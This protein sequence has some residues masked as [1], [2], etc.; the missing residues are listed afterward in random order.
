MSRRVPE[1]GLSCCA[2]QCSGAMR[3]G[4]VLHVLCCAVLWWCGVMR[5]DVG[6][7]LGVV[8]LEHRVE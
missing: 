4:A 8:H 2:M 1:L 3:C 5:C 6:V 7:G